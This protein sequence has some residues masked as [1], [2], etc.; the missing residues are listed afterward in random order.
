MS[1]REDAAHMDQSA[2][3]FEKQVSTRTHV[4]LIVV[5]RKSTNLRERKSCVEWKEARADFK[6]SALLHGLGY[7][8]EDDHRMRAFMSSRI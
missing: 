7:A 1:A 8:T 6:R 3:V 2:E 4:K 5:F